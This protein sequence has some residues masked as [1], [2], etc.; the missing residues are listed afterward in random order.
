MLI[1][2]L[3]L[4]VITGAIAAATQPPAEKTATPL[5]YVPEGKFILGMSEQ[6]IR[7]F[8]ATLEQ[9]YGENRIDIT[10]FDNALG[11]IPVRLDAYRIAAQTVTMAQYAEFLNAI[12]DTGQ[13]YHPEMADGATCGIRRV[14]NNYTVVSGREQ[15]PVVYVNWYDASAYAAWAGMRLPTEAEWE[16]AAR[17]TKGRRFPWGD[18]LVEKNTNHGRP[19]KEGD[20]PD[21]ADGFTN[22]A[23]VAAFPEGQTPLGVMNMAGNVWEWTADWYAPDAYG[24]ITGSNPTGPERGM[25]KVVR[26]G[27]FRS[28]GPTLSAIYRGKQ[29]PETIADDLGFRCVMLMGK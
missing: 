13:H 12:A 7:N 23:P 22:T 26:G 29:T 28:W 5:A 10:V 21:P 1:L 20:F 2:V 8:I 14:E 3:G 11:G 9:T 24:K 19:T 27:S 18:L 15:Y 6:G 16:R 25:R 17:G 4:A